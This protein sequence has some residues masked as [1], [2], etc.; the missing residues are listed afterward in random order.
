MIMRDWVGA[1][2]RTGL[3]WGW[4]WQ[5]SHSIPPSLPPSL[6]ACLAPPPAREETGHTA[7]LLELVQSAGQRREGERSTYVLYTTR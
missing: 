4:R 1:V 3:G 2:C 6:S 7:P 5:C